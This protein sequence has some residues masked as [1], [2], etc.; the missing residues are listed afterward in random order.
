M[1][2]YHEAKYW[3]RLET[4][5]RSESDENK[6]QCV[7]CPHECVISDGRTGICKVRK[8]I[9]G[10]LYSLNYG[11]VTS[12]ALDP[13]EKKPLFHFYPGSSIISVGTWGC[14]FRCAFCQNWEISQQRPYYV[15]RIEPYELVEI[16][17]EYKHEGNI[18]IAYTYSEPIVWYE[19]VLETAKLAREA[20]LKNVLVTNGYINHEP[21]AELGK[22][23][24]AMNIDLK[25]FNN[26][27]YRKV[28][29]GDFEHVLNTIKYCVYN[30]IH[31]EVTTLVIP[32]E[33]DDI[34]ELEEE[35]KALVNISKDIPLHLS[36]YHP[37]YKYT[38]PATSVGKLIDIYNSA[39]KYLNYVYLGNV[40][41]EKYESTYCPKCGNVVI[42][43][44][45]YNIEI[46]NLDEEGRCKVCSNQILRNL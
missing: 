6:L 4:F 40:W 25:A 3:K 21:L 5:G 9:E 33:N 15:K 30:N 27:F 2:N 24:D 11:E 36:R 35:F 38:K 31:V 43:R 18:G 14:N 10:K 32:G 45:G 42:I 12:M 37:A 26:E 46:V 28:C 19:F 34:Q 16:A 13:I 17:L 1:F 39:K 8:N 20:G 22:F 41:D 7:L 29:G 44:K 23:I